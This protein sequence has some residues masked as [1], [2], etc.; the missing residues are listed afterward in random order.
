MPD[1]LPGSLRCAKVAV[2]PLPRICGIFKLGRRRS[3]MHCAFELTHLTDIHM[4]DL[5]AEQQG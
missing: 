5:L 4:T 3:H 2:C 1:R